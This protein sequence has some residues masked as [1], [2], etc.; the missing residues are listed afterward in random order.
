MLSVMAQSL[1]CFHNKINSI[2]AFLWLHSINMDFCV[3]LVG[4]VA[5]GF[6]FSTLTVDLPLL[7]SGVKMDTG[8]LVRR[9]PNGNSAL[10]LKNDGEF[11]DL[12]FH[13]QHVWVAGDLE[14]QPL[15]A[16]INQ[17]KNHR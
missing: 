17:V 15:S 14:I 3:A 10:I 9:Q 13:L 6:E 1:V 5:D 2:A 7:R 12:G 11:T 4:Q 8:S 16:F